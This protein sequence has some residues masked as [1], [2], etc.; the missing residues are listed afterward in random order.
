MNDLIEALQIFAKYLA[1]DDYAN[2][3]PTQ[4]SH[5]QLSVNLRADQVTD[6]TDRARLGELGFYADAEQDMW[7]SFRFGSC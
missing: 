1:P 5:D 6:Q 7:Y 3:A 2:R 4:C